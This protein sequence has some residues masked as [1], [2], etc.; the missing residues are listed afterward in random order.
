MTRQEFDKLVQRVEV[1]YAGRPALLLRKC[2][3]FVFLGLGGLVGFFLLVSLA[4]LVLLYLI[5]HFFSVLPFALILL[6]TL[7]GLGLLAYSFKYV[8]QIF[9]KP[10]RIR[11][12]VEITAQNVP[13]LYQLIQQTTKSLGVRPFEKI[14]IMNETGAHVNYPYR[15]S[16]FGKVKADL[17][18]GYPLLI[19]YT[20]EELAAVIAHECAHLQSA[21]ILS[22]EWI[23][24]CRV[25]WDLFVQH[26]TQGVLSNFVR[27]FW[28]RFNAHAFVLSRIQEYDADALAARHVSSKAISI[29]LIKLRVHGEILSEEFWPGFW[30]RAADHPTPPPIALKEMDKTI[31]KIGS[32]DNLRRLVSTA[33]SAVSTT[34]DTHPCLSD[35]LKSLQGKRIA[36]EEAEQS[37]HSS[38]VTVENLHLK[39]A[40]ES[41]TTEL[42]EYWVKASARN[43]AS[44]HLRENTYKEKSGVRQE[45]VER[46]WERAIHSLNANDFRSAEPILRDILADRPTH[47][48]AKFNLAVGL[49]NEDQPE[50]L[51]LADSILEVNPEY[52]GDLY[53]TVRNYHKRA[54]QTSQ[55]EALTRRMDSLEKTHT[56]IHSERSEVKASDNFIPHTLSEEVIS[57]VIALIKMEPSVRLA[58]LARKTLIHSPREKIFILALTFE[59]KWG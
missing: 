47:F 49:L 20:E 50:G 41:I 46:L 59:K 42:T 32:N 43:W 40:K 33:L 53:H 29:A 8:R 48:G 11:D 24:R 23:Y 37:F 44:R 1:T 3:Q 27:W 21:H 28:P 31:L 34:E 30:K 5:V 38:F 54:G 55:I 51:Q 4:G 58:H 36:P 6:G 12:E 15:F 56:Q 18:L 7:I 25:A 10:Q 26:N 45:Y 52:F 13:S 16:L 17:H 35:R 2:L 57:N 22:G 39:E 14:W 19:F 9:Y